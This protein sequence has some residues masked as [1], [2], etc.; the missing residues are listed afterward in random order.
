M[1]YKNVIFD[2]DGTLVDSIYGIAYSMNIVL[3]KYGF[4]IHTID[5]YKTLVG[6]GRSELVRKALPKEV[7]EKGTISTYILDMITTYA[8]FW[9]YHLNVYDGILT[10][11]NFLSKNEIKINVNTNKDEATT[12]LILKRYFSSFDFTTIICGDSLKSKKPDPEGAICIAQRSGYPI[13][14]SI[15]IGDSEIDIETARNAQMK[16]ISIEWGFRPKTSL[17]AA[18]AETI[19]AHPAEIIDFLTT[20]CGYTL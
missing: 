19:V 1:N 11:L 10:L 12:H 9:D 16:C 6:S 17:I 7:T 20:K 2:L 3:A 14:Q 15:Y 13:S 5:H 18:G 8:L 4:P